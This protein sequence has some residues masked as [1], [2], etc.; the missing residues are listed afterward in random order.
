MK[1]YIIYIL[2]AVVIIGIIV[3]LFFNNNIFF[4]ETPSTISGTKLSSNI[5]SISNSENIINNE[6]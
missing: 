6:I 1:K 5:N 3:F 4:K 2:I